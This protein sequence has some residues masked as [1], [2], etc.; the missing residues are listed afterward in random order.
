MA[1]G[2]AWALAVEGCGSS[3]DE[4]EA[5]GAICSSRASQALEP[6]DP[7]TLGVYLDAP[8]D[9]GIALLKAD[10]GSYLGQAWGVP[11]LVVESGA[12]PGSRENAVWI[13]T[14]DAARDALGVSVDSGYALGRAQVG[15]GTRWIVY[16]PGPTELAYG[17]YAFLEELGF[18][19]FHPMQELVPQ[20]GGAAL[21][22]ELAL[23]R[24]P[25]FRIRGMQPHT[26]HP[27]EYLEPLCEPGSENLADARR[28]VDWLVKTGQNL[29]QWPL[30]DYA[31]FAE[32]APHAT[33]IAE[34]AHGRGVQVG[35]VVQMF[36][37]SALQ[38]NY[39]LIRDEASWQ[40]E[41]EASLDELMTVPWDH[42]VLALGEFIG[43]DPSD[44]IVWLNHATT[45]LA[46]NHP[47]VEVSAQVHVGNY[48]GLWIDYQGKQKF[49]YH[50]AGE[51]DPRLT[52]SV[53]TV[54]FFDL[55]RDWGTYKHDDF[56]FQRDYLFAELP[57]RKVSYFPESAYWIAA[58]V[59]VP[60]F[61]PEYV[62]SRWL[63]IHSLSKDI[64]D[65][66][67]PS[68]D[69]HIMFSSGHEWGYWLTD[70]LAAKLLWN[71]EA[72]FEE[73]IGHFTSAFGPCG[74]E[75]QHDL[76][77]LV[78]LQNQYLFDQR[79][80]GYVSGEDNLL[81]VG[82]L[83]GYESHPRR[84][85]Y[86]EV[87]ALEP[88]AQQAFEQEVVGGLEAMAQA[89]APLEQSVAARCET[90]DAALAPWCDELA[91]GFA[92]D[93]LRASHSALLYRAVLDWARGGSE[94]AGLLEKA[95]GERALAAEVVARRAEGYR[96]PV[97]KLVDHYD[98]R[99]IY[100]FGYLRQAHTLCFWDRQ[101][102]QA[103][104]LIE[105]GYPAGLAALP[106]CH[107]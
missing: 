84:K 49:F 20:L 81:D 19:F 89:I 37:A 21:P 23:V 99:T 35:A 98:N 91:D 63:D 29:L 87:A 39:V 22:R 66:G 27:I 32:Y 40:S 77:E 46:D 42:V 54:F 102:Q 25:A 93:R 51:A 56:F 1:L 86:E 55:Y 82:W 59:D 33:A 53:H 65:K 18:R 101:E 28:L 47:N 43:N 31:S 7:A 17:S 71:P 60:Q 5:A 45:Y 61:L 64:A 48:P 74:T 72:S 10:L 9:A 92:I 38:N 6:V 90:A 103:K 88:A 104:S 67:L 34:H 2:I 44:V 62:Y 50:L 78:A 96:F 52:S 3:G 76:G 11:E 97:S 80:I 75:L 8:D 73:T 100:E 16:A 24:K 79:L 83:A 58:D 94:H 12:P 57:E 41:L 26:L 15:E 106:T 36:G 95:S 68:L 4:T 13:S 30:L 70:Y 107:D 14:S 85:S 105:T 69:G